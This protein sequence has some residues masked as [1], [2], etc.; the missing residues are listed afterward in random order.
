MSQEQKDRLTATISILTLIVSVIW[1]IT[2]PKF[3]TLMLV[4]S[5]IATVSALYAGRKR[6]EKN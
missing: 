2:E 5:T 4:L 6:A 3:E 1:F